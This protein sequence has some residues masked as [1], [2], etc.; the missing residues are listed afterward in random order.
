MCR[1][2]SLNG[3]G[4]GTWVVVVVLGRGSWMRRLAQ[5]TAAVHLFVRHLD[6]VVVILAAAVMRKMALNMK[7]DGLLCWVRKHPS[8][9]L[10]VRAT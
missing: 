1:E 3:G 6:L 10:S 7:D 5:S 4:Q 2:S 8:V 9:V